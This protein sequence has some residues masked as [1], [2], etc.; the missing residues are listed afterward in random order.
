MKKLTTLL[1]NGDGNPLSVIP[2]SVISWQDAVKLIYLDKV[3]VVEEYQE[4]IHSQNISMNVPSVVMLRQYHKTGYTPEFTREN[5]FY[6]DE[7]KCQYCGEEFHTNDLTVDHV[8]P[9]SHGGKKNFDNAV[10]ACFPCNQKKA[11][12]YIK[13]L[14]TPRVPSYFELVHKR[15]K[16]PV[17]VPDDAWMAY[18][19]PS[20]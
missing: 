16:F 6:R 12:K 13:P 3:E 7:F 15:M 11:N 10:V 18:I 2:L 20:K 14:T 17:S 1:L 5:L 8:I 9:R 4:K 19:L